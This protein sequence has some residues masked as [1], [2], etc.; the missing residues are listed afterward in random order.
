MMQYE[1]TSE[2]N[3]HVRLTITSEAACGESQQTT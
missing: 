1:L 2:E 3:Q